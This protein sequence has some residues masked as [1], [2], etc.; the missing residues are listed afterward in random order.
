MWHDKHQQHQPGK[1]Y[2]LIEMK[3]CR[4]KKP[5]LTETAI[6]VLTKLATPR[7]RFRFLIASISARLSK[8]RSLLF[9]IARSCKTS[10]FE[11]RCVQKED[12]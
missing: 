8:R 5:Q 4:D 1:T 6:S 7:D 9:S 2:S 12:V 3:F 10:S 11:Q